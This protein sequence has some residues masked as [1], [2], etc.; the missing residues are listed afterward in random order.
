MKEI[1]VF[2]IQLDDISPPVWR[3]LEIR[4]EK[5]FW[6][7]HCAIQDAMPWEDRHLHAFQF[8]T[9]DTNV[10]IGIPLDDPFSDLEFLPSWETPLRDWFAAVPAQCRYQYDFG[11]DWMHTLTLEA[12]RPAEP[13]GRYPRCTGGEGRCPP[14]DVGGPY[15]YQN[16]LEALADPKHEEHEDFRDWIGTDQWDTTHFDPAEVVFSNALKRLRE[17]ELV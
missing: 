15:G 1:L 5:T 16:F 6:D 17:A 12:R 4:R 7:L 10:D 2:H 11:D 13:R 3:R 14:E 9:G 8:S